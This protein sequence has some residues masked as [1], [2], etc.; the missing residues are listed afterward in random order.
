[1]RKPPAASPRQALTPI[2]RE[3]GRL[4]RDGR[5]RAAD[6]AGRET[7]HITTFLDT[8]REPIIRGLLP[9]LWECTEGGYGCFV[10]GP[11]GRDTLRIS[12]DFRRWHI[13]KKESPGVNAGVQSLMIYLGCGRHVSTHDLMKLL[14]AASARTLLRKDGAS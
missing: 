13:H 3:L 11:D 10:A 8:A 5:G 1:M 2:A 7:N 9:H 6:I 4:F 14:G 12:D